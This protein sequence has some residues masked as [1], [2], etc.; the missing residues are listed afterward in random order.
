MAALLGTLLLALAQQSP[1]PPFSL[2]LPEGYESFVQPAPEAERWSSTR[3]DGLGVFT[4]EHL[5]VATPGGDP[6]AVAREIRTFWLRGLQGLEPR[7][8]DWSGAWGGFDA[9]GVDIR[10]TRGGRESVVL[11]R[12]LLLGDRLVHGLWEGPAAQR[13]QA[14]EAFASFRVPEAWIPLPPPEVDPWSG[15]GEAGAEQPFPGE[16]RIHADLTGVPGQQLLFVEVVWDGPAG[17]EAGGWLYPPGSTPVERQGSDG[18]G[19]RYRLRIDG[20]AGSGA[21]YGMARPLVGP[22][23]AALDAAWLAVPNVLLDAPAGYQ[24]PAWTLRLTYPAS[25][26][27]FS[28]APGAHGFVDK[29][30]YRKVDYPRLAAGRAW[31]FFLAGAYKPRKAGSRTWNLRLDAKAT[32]PDE[33]VRGVT[34]LEKALGAWLRTAPRDVQVASFPGLGDRALPGLLVLD[35]TAGWFNEP[36]DAGREGLTQRIWLARAI[37]ACTFG[38]GLRGVGSAAPFLEASL[39]EYGA[40]RLLEAEWPDDAAVLAAWWQ[41]NEDALGTLP[42]PLSMMPAEDS[43]GAR[44]LQSRGAL[45]WRAIETRAGRAVL[46]AVL[47]AALAAGKPWSTSAL[48]TALETRT[49]D[50]WSGFF[51]DHVYG[52]LT[53]RTAD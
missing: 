14:L 25:L 33:A 46:D 42:M 29:G 21:P 41:A 11:E 28:H 5:L 48:Q 49:E 7:A 9:A 6:G 39:A 23:L 19:V 32:L 45:V 50:D 13:E 52:R 1:A 4:I 31:P 2:T 26:T 24:A 38:A 53:P 17:M 10:F 12:I 40:W 8:E 44:R 34:R 27:V 47:D 22:G 20:E 15:L 16:F 37:G 30:G 35:E 36:L 43:F 3:A 51:R 18:E